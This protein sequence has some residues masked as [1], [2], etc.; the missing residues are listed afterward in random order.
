[1]KLELPEVYLLKTAV[2]SIN[3]KATDAPIVAKVLEKLDR[4]FNRLQKLEE[5]KKPSNGVATVA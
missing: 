1:M 4:E 3:I 5:K 2:E